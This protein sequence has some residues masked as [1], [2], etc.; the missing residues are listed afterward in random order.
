MN[1]T[2]ENA[3]IDPGLET[4]TGRG[5]GGRFAKGNKGGPGNPDAPL[6][7][8]HRAAFFA[9]IKSSDA[10]SALRVIRQLMNDADARPADRLAAAR[11]LLDRVIGRATSSDVVQR[12]EAL[13]QRL[14]ERDNK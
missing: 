4:A 11:E 3:P 10:R 9:A 1:E 12:I 8:K 14:L 2:N 5:P 6:V 13:E 7:A